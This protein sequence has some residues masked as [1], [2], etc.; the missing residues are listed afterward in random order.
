ML[1]FD[2][3]VKEMTLIRPVRLASMDRFEYL[4]L[5]G[6]MYIDLNKSLYVNRGQ[7][8]T[9]KCLGYCALRGKTLGA[10]LNPCLCEQ[11]CRF[12][13]NCLYYFTIGL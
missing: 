3:H 13:Y 6:W 9:G 5:C 1:A 12:C 2:D 4:L 11:N 8:F 10:Q 7:C